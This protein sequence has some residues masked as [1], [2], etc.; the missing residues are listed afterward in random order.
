MGFYRLLNRTA[1]LMA[2]RRD[3]FILGICFLIAFVESALAIETKIAFLSTRD[4][5]AEIYAT[6]SDWTAPV[7][8]TR[9]PAIDSFPAWSPDGTKIAFTS[10]RRNGST[11]EIYIMGADGKRP[12]RLTKNNQLVP[13]YDESPSWSPDGRKIAFASN[14]EGNSEIYVMHVKGKKIV[15]LTVTVATEET[16]VWS[17]DG[18]K[19]AFASGIVFAQSDIFVMN[20]NGANPVNLTQNPQSINENPSWSPN[21]ERIAFQA[22]RRSNHDIY[23]MDADGSNVV[24][25]TH[26]FAW[27]AYPAWSPDGRKIAFTSLR[28]LVGEEIF[29]MNPNGTNIVQLTHSSE[30]WMNRMASWRPTPQAV[31]SKGKLVIHWGRVKQSR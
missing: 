13:A 25:L 15:R 14:R 17:P 20:A 29:L 24:R 8:L 18:M 4:G 23:V 26:H 27:D 5:N 2:L 16:P 6:D 12:V 31:F 1:R 28:N 11:Y 30:E 3:L 19:I 7:R 9:H 10:N 22:W 21:G